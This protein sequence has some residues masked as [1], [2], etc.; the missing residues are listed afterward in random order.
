MPADWSSHRSLPIP[1]I[2]ASCNRVHWISSYPFANEKIVKQ[3]A[4]HHTLHN[5]IVRK[6]PPREMANLGLIVNHPPSPPFL[7]ITLLKAG[8]IAIQ[9][10][11]ICFEHLRKC[12]LRR[13]VGEEVLDSASVGI[14]GFG[15]FSFE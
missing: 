9:C 3:A 8:N 14:N 7:G 6:F 12:L 4:G 1:T 11:F 2:V 13:E 10:C 15:A 5:G